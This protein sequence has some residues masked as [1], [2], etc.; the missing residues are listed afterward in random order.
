[1]HPVFSVVL[2]FNFLSYFD[3]HYCTHTLLLWLINKLRF[4]EDLRNISKDM[5]EDQ[6]HKVIHQN[7]RGNLISYMSLLIV[8]DLHVL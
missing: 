7:L 2:H 6:Y 8:L 3:G 4:P 1:M 5:K